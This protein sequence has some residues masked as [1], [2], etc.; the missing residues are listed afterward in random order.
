MQKRSDRFAVKLKPLLRGEN[1]E[2]LLMCSTGAIRT[3]RGD[4]V[5]GVR[6]SDDPSS[7]RYLFSG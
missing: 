7:E 2:R 1:V 5:K 4:R 3:H 6:N